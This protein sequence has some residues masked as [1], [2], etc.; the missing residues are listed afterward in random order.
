MAINVSSSI[1]ADAN[2]PGLLDWALQ[3]RD[4]PQ[5]SVCVEI[6]ETSILNQPEPD[7]VARV[8]HLRRIGVRVALDDFGTGYAGLAQMSLLKVDQIKLDCCLVRRLESDPRTRVITRALIR[9]CALLGMDVVAEGVE[10]QGQLDILRRARCPRAQ[11]YALAHPMP[12]PDIITWLHA[13][14]PLP[15]TVPPEPAKHAALI[16][17]AHRRDNSV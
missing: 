16:P 17:L 15:R 14:T 12:T 8:E 6:L 11:G 5:S 1:L 7:V 13:N 2:Y 3:S 9:L 4:L 10:T